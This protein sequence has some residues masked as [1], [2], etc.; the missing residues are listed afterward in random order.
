MELVDA[1]SLLG[2]LD[3]SVALQRSYPVLAIGFGRLVQRRGTVPRDEQI[4]LDRDIRAFCGL[5]DEFLGL[6]NF[7]SRQYASCRGE[8]QV[9]SPSFVG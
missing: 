5:L 4:G 6:P 8:S 2:E 1:P 3:R 9:D 7:W